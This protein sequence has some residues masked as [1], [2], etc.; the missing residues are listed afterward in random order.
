MVC[1]LCCLMACYQLNQDCLMMCNR[2]AG[3]PLNTFFFIAVIIPVVVFCYLSG[4]NTNL[5]PN[6]AS[7][8]PPASK[9]LHQMILVRLRRTSMRRISCQSF[10]FFLAAAATLNCSSACLCPWQRYTLLGLCA[11]FVSVSPVPVERYMRFTH[12]LRF[13]YAQLARSLRWN[14][15]YLFACKQLMMY[16]LKASV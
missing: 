2:A 5:P 8:A 7:I 12:G 4:C 3:S 1:Q 9:R 6:A 14:H 16:L 11:F 10:F 15:L 13:C